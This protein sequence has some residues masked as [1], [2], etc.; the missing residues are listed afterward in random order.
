MADK[1]TF[2]GVN[3]GAEFKDRQI[4]LVKTIAQSEVFS[5]NQFELQISNCEAKIA[6]LEAKKVELQAKIDAATTKL[7]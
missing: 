3:T 1:Y 6:E 7:G 5:V 4:K 2:D